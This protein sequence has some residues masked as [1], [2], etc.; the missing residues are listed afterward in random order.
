[1]EISNQP[2]TVEIGDQSSTIEIDKSLYNKLIHLGI[3]PTEI[4]KS[5][6]GASNYSQH[7]IQPWSIWIDYNLNAWDADIVKRILRTK[8]EQGLS[9][10]EAR[11]MDYNKIIH[12]CQERIRQLELENSQKQSVEVNAP[13]EGYAE[14]PCLTYS[15]QDEE[16]K[17]WYD[18]RKK[19]KTCVGT[20]QITFDI[21]SG[22]GISKIAHCTGC[23]KTEDITDYNNW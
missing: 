4:R 12:I 9:K 21:S 8:S 14:D 1:M 2:S 7:V 23:N 10:Q 18:F 6:V 11:I 22:I 20:P 5:H 16:L 3:I 19:H 17:R 13:I 15:I